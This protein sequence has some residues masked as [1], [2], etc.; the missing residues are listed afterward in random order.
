[1]GCII[2]SCGDGFL[3]ANAEECDDGNTADGDGCSAVCGKERWS[4]VGVAADVPV[5][6]LTM[7]EQCWSGTYQA[8]GLVSDIGKACTGEHIMVACRPKGS[9]TLTLAAHAP[10]GD[11]FLEPQ[12]DPEAGERHEANGVAWYWSPW[13]GLAGFGPAGNTASCFDD[14]EDQQLCWRVGGNMPLTFNAGYRC[15]EKASMFWPD[16]S[17]ERVVYQAWD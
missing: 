10:R 12:V 15:G 2:A 16:A 11:V 13:Y 5:A 1:L 7:W 14:G 8:G 9:A 4:H 17:W 6:D 3:H